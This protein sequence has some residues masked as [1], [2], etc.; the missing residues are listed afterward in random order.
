VGKATV[1]YLRQRPIRLT[2]HN[3]FWFDEFIESFRSGSVF[4]NVIV[5]GIHVVGFEDDPQIHPVQGC[6]ARTGAL[7]GANYASIE[8]FDLV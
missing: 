2:L 1:D 4:E 7:E 3:V 8:Y 6:V 5:A